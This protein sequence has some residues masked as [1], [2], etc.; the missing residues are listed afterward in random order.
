MASCVTCWSEVASTIAV[1]SVADMLRE[2]WCGF[3][4]TRV[5]A[6]FFD[7]SVGSEI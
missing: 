1:G 3:A 4:T 6:S 2:N 7:K 5:Q